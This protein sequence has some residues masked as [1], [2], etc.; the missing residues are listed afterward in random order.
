[1]AGRGGLTGI[2]SSSEENS[3]KPEAV[4]ADS[5]EL[6]LP[7]ESVSP[8]DIS[9]WAGMLM[10]LVLI[11]FWP[12]AD[13]RLLWNDIHYVRPAAPTIIWAQ[14][15]QDPAHYPFGQYHPVT[16]T[17][18]WLI[19]NLFGQ[20]AA[21]GI[22]PFPFHLANLLLHG[23]AAVMLWLIL[24]EIKLPGA[25]VAAALFAVHPLNTQAVSWISQTSVVLA[26]L[27]FFA[28]VFAFLIFA[29][30]TR[31]MSVDKRWSWYAASLAL[32]VVAMLSKSTAWAMP[33]VTLMLL[34]WQRR[35]SARNAALLLPMLIIGVVL[36]FAA[37]DYE[38]IILTNAAVD[39][40]LTLL[41]RLSLIGRT[42]WFYIG[43]LLAP[44]NL[45]FL[46]PKWDIGTYSI[47]DLLPLA[48]VTALVLA[49]GRWRAAAVGWI[50]FLACLAPAMGIYFL[51]PMEHSYVAD[52]WAYLA[53]A[54]LIALIV[55]AAAWGLRKMHTQAAV[56][57]VLSAIVLLAA[58]GISWA[59]AQVFRDSVLLWQDTVA[60]NPASVFAHDRLA[61]AL[62]E[63]AEDDLAAGDKDS[64]DQKLQ[65]ALQQARAAA[66][67]D[68][69]DAEAHSTWGR[70]LVRLGDI[71]HAIEQLRLAVADGP[72][73]LEARLELGIQLI[74]V[75]KNEEAIK[76]L[77][78]ALAIEP[79][80]SQAH[81]LLGTAYAATNPQRAISEEKLAIDIDSDSVPAR[82]ELGKLLADAGDDK[83]ALVQFFLVARELHQKQKDDPD[84]WISIGKLVAR[85][86]N[87]GDAIKFFN[88][89][90][91]LDPNSKEARRNIDICTAALEKQRRQNATRPSTTQ[92]TPITSSG[93]SPATVPP[94]R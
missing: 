64:Y 44:M 17:L 67:L 21:G 45:S 56:S 62:A 40:N 49:V 50:C 73:L 63:S 26:G 80:S 47:T 79:Q 24:R 93:N 6:I 32:F 85:Q 86:G 51:L 31:Q 90:L 37:E 41:Q 48:L 83:G 60:K 33:I 28:S 92:A 18:D 94:A 91:G 11:A 74:S 89:A 34:W 84:I 15:W 27:F 55:G 66:E 3:P 43:K 20:D 46:Y 8:R 42:P 59:R 69:S 71:P 16:F 87:L 10:I 39:G 7:D 72:K 19:Y 75:G 77:D 70:I 30:P 68:D 36:C 65:Q 81:R 38:R 78:E 61:V 1:M 14:R 57:V 29:D 2:M 76:V 52:H 53:T 35:L 4:S 22:T 25:W 12:A 9:L 5:L 88:T 82:I 58:G 23:G 13:G 54:P